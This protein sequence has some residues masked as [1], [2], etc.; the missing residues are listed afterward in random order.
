MVYPFEAI[1]R[2]L[3]GMLKVRVA[4]GITDQASIGLLVSLIEP[5]IRILPGVGQ[6]PL[7]PVPVSQ[8]VFVV[9]QSLWEPELF[10]TSLIILVS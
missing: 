10:T 6:N 2:G 4:V 3:T 8:Q 9:V 5:S 1:T 7:P